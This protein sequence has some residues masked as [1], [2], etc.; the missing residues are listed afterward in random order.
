MDNAAFHPKEEIHNVL[1]DR[2]CTWCVCWVAHASPEAFRDLA[3]VA[4]AS[5]GGWRTSRMLR[6]VKCVHCIR[7]QYIYVHVYVE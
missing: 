3:N 5:P 6:Q 7:I 4:H 1:R 2:A